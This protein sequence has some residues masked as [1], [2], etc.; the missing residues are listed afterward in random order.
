MVGG[1]AFSDKELLLMDNRN[2]FAALSVKGPKR[3]RVEIVIKGRDHGAD[4]KVAFTVPGDDEESVD[5]RLVKVFGDALLEERIE[6]CWPA[7]ETV[8][9]N[10]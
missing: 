3:F 4:A 8:K 5:R 9:E 6:P 7:R 2:R 10:V 1:L